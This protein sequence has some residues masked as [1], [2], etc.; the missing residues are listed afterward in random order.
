MNPH[1]VLA[2]TSPYRKKLMEQLHIPFVTAKPLADEEKLKLASQVSL[3]DLPLFLAQKKAESLIAQ[4]PQHVIIGS[5]QMGVLAGEPLNKPGTKDKAI[6]QLLKM[7][8]KTHTLIT[9]M[10]VYDRGQWYHHVDTTHLHMKPLSREQIVRYVDLDNPV[11]CAGSYKM[12]SLGVALFKK[13]ETQDHTAIVGL[14][15]MGLVA[16]LDR[17]KKGPLL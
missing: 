16:I 4:Y 7:E 15:L 14:P 8:S 1:L 17:I 11:D 5:D 13:I 3:T 6:E 2:S 10:S 9:A 12:E